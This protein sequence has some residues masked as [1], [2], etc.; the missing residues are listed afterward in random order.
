MKTQ[1]TVQKISKVLYIISKVIMILIFVS[2][3]ITLVSGIMMFSMSGMELV[4]EIIAEAFVEMDMDYT[5]F[6]MGIMML[7][8]A[9]VL[10]GE[11]IVWMYAR[12]YFKHQLDDGTPFTY[13][14]ADEL[15]ALGIRVIAWPLGA[16]VVSTVVSVM[17]GVSFENE[18]SLDITLGIAC[19]LLS[20]VFR[21]G[22]ELKEKADAAEKADEQSFRTHDMF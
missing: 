1:G 3:G 7:C 22:A 6:D 16:M 12:N 5:A 11:G 9:L 8:E 10:V 18:S 15:K 17:F 14:G 4:D 21:H 20:F 13:R 19:I 2:A